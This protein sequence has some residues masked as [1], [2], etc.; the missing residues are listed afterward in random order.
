[1]LTGNGST[2]GTRGESLA[3]YFVDH[4]PQPD[5]IV[6]PLD[7]EDEVPVAGRSVAK[8]MLANPTPVP[9]ATCI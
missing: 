1:M 7:S 9:A 2:D 5:V 3:R 4:T 6:G 8:P